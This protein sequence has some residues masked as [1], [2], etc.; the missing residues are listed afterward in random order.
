MSSSKKAEERNEKIIR[1]LLKLPPNRKCINCNSSGPQ[2]VCTSFW[3]FIC[4]TCSGVHREFSHR[5]KSV[6]LS[7]FTNQEVE[8]LQRGG[9]QRAREIFLKDWDS[10][11]MRLPDSSKIDKLREFIKNVY[12]DKKYAGGRSTDKPPRDTQ[13]HRN[14]EEH[15]RASSYHSYSQSPPYEYQYE[16]RRYGKQ[17]GMLS[18]KPGSDRG[19]YEG[20]ISSFICSPGSQRDQNYEDR[21]ANES[22]GSRNSDYSVSSCG[23]PFRVDAQSPNFQEAGYSSPPSQPVRDILIDNARP[24]TTISYS[25]STVKSESNG[26]H[27]SQRTASSGSFGSFDSTSPKSANSAHDPFPGLS[28]GGSHEV[29][30]STETTNAESWKA[31]DDTSVGGLTTFPGTLPQT[32]SGPHDDKLSDNTNYNSQSWNTFDDLGKSIPQNLSWTLPHVSEI[33]TSV[34]MPQATN[35]PFTGNN[36]AEVSSKDAFQKLSLDQFAAFSAPFDVVGDSFP[37]SAVPSVAGSTR[38]QKSTNP[39]DLPFDSDLEADNMFMDMSSLKEALPD[40]ELP[41]AFL[42]N[43]SE[44]WFPH[45]SITT[46]IPSVPQGGLAYLAGPVSGA[47]LPNITSQAAV[48]S[49]GGNPFA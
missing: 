1:G 25:Q 27:R 2:Y 14:H 19:N 15:R 4:L 7:T 43:L 18:R 40:P 29:K 31:F 20:K 41:A 17:T 3:T 11:Q 33:Q 8:A 26:I 13:N 35:N 48:A 12:V 10:Q 44:T 45:N 34:S 37:S 32:L 5:V 47:Q 6:S 21:F 9:N 24:H 38:E 46:Y 30:G 23:D 36:V 49:L 22:C 39:F 28:N 42:D 16:E